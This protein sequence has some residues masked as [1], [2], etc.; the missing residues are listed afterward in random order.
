MIL[1]VILQT[2]CIR[3]ENLEEM[4]STYQIKKIES[5]ILYV[6]RYFQDGVDYIKLF[7]IIYFSQREYLA[8]YGKVLCPDTFKARTYG[9]VPALSDKVIKRVELN[10]DEEECIDLKSFEESIAVRNQ[11]VFAMKEPDMDYLSKKECQCLDKWYDYCKDK[12]SKKELSPESHDEAYETAFKRMQ[13]DPQ[14]GTMTNIE[15]ARA[16]GASD[17]MI[18]YIRNKELLTADFA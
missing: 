12:D 18:E 7:K 13:K 16:G 14:L 15:I 3:A 17:K 6:L 1:F 5:V 11:L 4:K 8:K 10:D 9:P 2:Q